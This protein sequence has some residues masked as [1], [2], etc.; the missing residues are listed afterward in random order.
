MREPTSPSSVDVLSMLMTPGAD[1]NISDLAE[2]SL[3]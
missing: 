3:E 1:E 2:S